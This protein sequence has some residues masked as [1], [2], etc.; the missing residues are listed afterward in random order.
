M[1]EYDRQKHI[2]DHLA[3]L[4]KWEVRRNKR[5]EANTRDKIVVDSKGLAIVVYREEDEY[6]K[7][8]RLHDR[9]FKLMLMWESRF[10][11][12]WRPT[13]YAYEYVHVV[14]DYRLGLRK[15]LSMPKWKLKELPRHVRMQ[16]RDQVDSI[17]AAL[18]DID[19]LTNGE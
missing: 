7:L 5:I 15:T 17:I 16:I 14:V 12:D 10:A 9:G 6:D 13:A 8:V 19:E 1:D 4:D 18:K 3:M 11:G 2:R